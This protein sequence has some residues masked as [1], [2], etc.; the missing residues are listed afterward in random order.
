LIKQTATPKN[1][2]SIMKLTEELLKTL[3]ELC[4]QDEAGKK[5]FS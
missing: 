2:I 5:L 3:E 4:G 1:E